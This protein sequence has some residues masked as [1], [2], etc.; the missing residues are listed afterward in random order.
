MIAGDNNTGDTFFANIN[1]TGEQLL[2]VT[3]TPAITFFPGVVDTGHKKT[4][5]LK[6]I[7][8]VND[9]SKHLFTGINDTGDKLFP[10]YTGV[11]DTGDKAVL[12]ILA[13]LHLKMKNKQ[14]FNL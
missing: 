6:F 1:N 12:P 13:C 2:L 3:T 4:K 7:A 9:T 11:I 5:S 14:K 8:S 10:M